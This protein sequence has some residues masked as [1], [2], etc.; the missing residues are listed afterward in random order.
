MLPSDFS[1]HNTMLWNADA[2]QENVDVFVASGVIEEILPAGKRKAAP[3]NFDA[4][5]A[6]LLPSGVDNQVHTRLPG[7]GHKENPRH[8]AQAA[9]MGGYGALLAMPNTYPVIDTPERF[10]RCFDEWKPAFEQTG[11]EL[12]Q[13]SALSY[14]LASQKNVDF[15]AMVKAGAKVFTDDGVALVNDE[16]MDE[17]FAAAEKFGFVILQHAEM[18][19]HGGALAGSKV[20]KASG[21]PAYPQ[22][23]E[24]KIVERDLRLLRRHPQARYHVLHVTTEQSVRLIEA[25]QKEGLK[26]TGE[27]SPH[28]LYFCAED[29]VEGNYSFKMNPPL[30]RAEDRKVLRAALSR[31][32]LSFVATDHAPHEAW[33]KSQGWQKAPFGTTGLESSLRVL[34]LMIQEGVLRGPEHLVEVFSSKPAE[35]L[36]LKSFG[37]LKPGSPFQAVLLDPKRPKSALRESDLGSLSHNNVFLGVELPGRILGHFNSKGF[38]KFQLR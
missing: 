20:Q 28:H 22:E 26:V 16:L 8:V 12:L 13:T 35:F 2:V 37:H 32:V 7:Q 5:G 1:I 36:G 21:L 9:L 18:P 29:I 17:A 11:V 38:F 15:A 31:G 23:A 34:L 19:G 3:S 27:V 14:N 10:A 24:S 33:A 6:V 25:A 30:F 4:Q